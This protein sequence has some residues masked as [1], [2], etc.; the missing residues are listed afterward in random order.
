M[1]QKAHP[2][3]V[4]LEQIL[5]ILAKE[6]YTSPFAFLR[7]NIQNAY[8]AIRMQMFRDKNYGE[9]QEHR[10]VLALDGNRL[11]I[12]DTGI[13]MS[14]DDLANYFWS[15]GKSGKHT[16]EA[17]AAGVVGTFGIGGMANFGICSRLA[18]MTKSHLSNETIFSF[19]DRSN[20]SAKENCVFY[21]EGPKEFSPGT[22][23]T[24]TLLQSVTQ[25]Q[26]R[27]YLIPFV[28]FID[29]PVYLGNMLLSG[30][31]FPQVIR[32]EGMSHN[33]ESDRLKATAYFRVLKNGQAEIEVDKLSW[34][35]Q[36][37][38]ISAI[39]ST[40]IGVVS[41][42][43]HGFMLANVPISSTFALGGII[44]SS[45]LRPTAG[46]EAV[47]DESRI[48]V[49]NLLLAI[50]AGLATHISQNPGLSDR[51]SDFYKYLCQLRRWEL[52]GSATVRVYGS[53]QRVRLDSLKSSP[54]G[55]VYFARDGH[56]KSIMQSY[57][58]Q[59]KTIAILS[60]DA[61]R[62]KVE[63]N[64]LT[65]YC[66]ATLLEDRVTCLRTVDK[67]SFVEGDLRFQFHDRLRR[68]FFIDNLKVCAGE[69]SHNAMLWVA[70]SPS[71]KQKTLFIDFR[72][73]QIVRLAELRESPAF[74]AVFD[75]FI[76][77][78]VLPHLE[79]V[80]PDLQKRDFDALLR[81]LQSIVEYYEVDPEDIGRIRQLA[82]ITNMSPEDIAA[83]FGGRSSHISQSTSIK[84]SDVTTVTDQVNQV[85]EQ[86]GT[87]SMEDVRRELM[88]RLLE[89]ETD[90]KIL[91]ASEVD[92]QIG[93][94]RFYT[95][96]TREAH[97]LYRRIFIERNPTT[98]FSW[99][100]HRAGYLF[101]SLGTAV[102][103]YDIQFEKLIGETDNLKRTGSFTLEYPALVFKNQVFLPIPIE[104][105]K[106]LVPTKDTLKLTIR[107]KILGVDHTSDTWLS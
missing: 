3:E 46:R 28:Q 30:N 22:T 70:P 83:V 13:G 91:D 88:I 95:A 19:A 27:D 81:K 33:V 50:E 18:V 51:F 7:E 10:I 24:G 35:D 9:S 54:A 68:R 62:R 75:V 80:F 44:N 73:S 86:V 6:I 105:E 65:I 59:K 58:E 36:D 100:G 82:S 84:R 85:V 96:L 8:D 32:S 52:A 16:P 64:F 49:Q 87:R 5:P 38:D 39:F 107:H 48:L 29:V 12:S 56:D 97:I 17:Q 26:I 2:I 47:T 21:E 72:H 53:D 78:S 25:E 90:A 74:D 106:F 77:D 101:Y 61:Y 37:V 45:L 20:L 102:V 40:K 41:A 79:A 57:A 94:A 4:D 66:N 89:T 98:D 42:Y 71:S 92:S 76:R 99:G 43:Q 93:L 14:K 69:L 103:Y 1:S 11:S 23:V 104:F 55:Q 63:Q 15:I 67:L 60:S 34:N 31:S